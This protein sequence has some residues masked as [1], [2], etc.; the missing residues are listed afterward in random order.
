MLGPA[1]RV[2]AMSGISLPV[3][4]LADRAIEVELDDNTHFILEFD[5]QCYVVFS[6]HFVKGSTR[7]P[8][9][10]LYGERG[11]VVM[12]GGAEGTYELFGES[13]E[14][15][16]HGKVERLIQVGDPA[17]PGSSMRGAANYVAADAIH[18]ADRILEER[19][20]L[21]GAEHGRHVVEIIEQVYE[22]ARSGRRLDL[23]T[24]FPR[25]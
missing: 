10:E 1:R 20:P 23:A 4:A 3:P 22:S 12:G 24:T 25:Y 13:E 18:L 21:I 15:D 8:R 6:S 11:A 2:T 17:P 5:G 9:L 16:R 14:R 19:E 7:T